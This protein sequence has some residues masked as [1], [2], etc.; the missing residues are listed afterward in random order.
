MSC[1]LR[2]RLRDG[3]TDLQRQVTNSIGI[4]RSAPHLYKV[5]EIVSLSQSPITPD[6]EVTN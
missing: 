4:A 1:F 3:R 2:F 6:V 5:L